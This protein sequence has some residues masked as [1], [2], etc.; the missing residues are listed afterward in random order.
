MSDYLVLLC[1]ANVSEG[2]LLQ[3]ATALFFSIILR[4]NLED[5]TEE[6]VDEDLYFVYG[7]D[8]GLPSLSS[9]KEYLLQKSI[10]E[11]YLGDVPIALDP[12]MF[13]SCWKAV[14]SL[15]MGF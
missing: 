13:F 6:V 10:E 8:S 14:R 12:Q 15:P 1:I 9:I 4:W 5:L 3:R 11:P 7:G 2:C